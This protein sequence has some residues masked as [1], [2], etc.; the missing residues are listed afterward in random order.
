MK[1]EIIGIDKLTPITQKR[2]KTAVKRLKKNC[3]L[4]KDVVITFRDIEYHGYSWTSLGK[5]R[6][7]IKPDPCKTCIIDTLAHEWA[8]FMDKAKAPHSKSWG[9]EYSKCY[10]TVYK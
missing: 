7:D 10:R 2:V 4:K 1:V 8:H 3:K 5:H 9:I 6:I